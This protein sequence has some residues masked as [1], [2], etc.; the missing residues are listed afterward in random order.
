MPTPDELKARGLALL[1]QIAEQERPCKACG[2]PLWFVRSRRT[3][4]LLPITDELTNH[5]ADCPRREEFRRAKQPPLFDTGNPL[6]P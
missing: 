5:F 1:H 3:G 6:P 2:R 4:R